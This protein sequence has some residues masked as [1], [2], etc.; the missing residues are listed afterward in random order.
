MDH[1]QAVLQKATFWQRFGE[2]TLTARQKNILN[3]FMDGFKGKLT[4]QKWAALGK[5][6]VDTAHRDITNLLARGL[7]VKNPGSGKRTSYSIPTFKMDN[8]ATAI[9]TE[10]A[11]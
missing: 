9:I 8:P 10:P 11:N 6:S 1:S 5:C 4:S 2:E 3:R 7:L